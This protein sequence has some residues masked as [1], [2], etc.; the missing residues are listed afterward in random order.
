MAKGVV[1]VYVKVKLE[2]ALLGMDGDLPRGGPKQFEIPSV[3]ETSRAA[4]VKYSA[5]ME[6]CMLP[7][8]LESEL[9]DF[10]EELRQPPSNDELAQG[11]SPSLKARWA[12]WFLNFRNRLAAGEET[13]PGWGIIRAMDFDGVST[14]PLADQASRLGRLIDQWKKGR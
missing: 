2:A 4:S 12:D 14:S 5:P 13:P 3:G 7:E 1:D 9:V 10:I 6:H 8:A 11:W